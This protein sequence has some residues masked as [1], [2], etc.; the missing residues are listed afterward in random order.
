VSK[1]TREQKLELITLLEEKKKRD[2]TRKPAYIPTPS[3]KG[4]IESKALERYLF[5]GN[6]WGKS[7]L[8]VNEM[9]WAAVGYNPFTKFREPGPSKI[10]LVIDNPRKIND[11]LAEYQKWHEVKPEQLHKKGKPEISM[12]SYENGSTITVLTHDVNPLTLEGSQW[13][14]IFMDEPPPK[15]VYT[16]V[17]RGG[18]IKGRPLRLLLAGTPISAAWLRIDIWEPYTKGELNNVECFRGSTL[19]NA[20]NIEMDRVQ[21]YWQKLSPDELKIRRDGSFYDLD[22]LALAHLFR[23]ETHTVDINSLSW[24]RNNPCVLVIDPHPSKPHHAVI[25][26]VDED[27]YLYVLDEYQEKAVARKFISSLIDRGWFERYRIVDFVYDSLGNSEMTSGEGF[28]PFGNVINEVLAQNKLGRAR[29]TTYDDKNDEQFI[30]RIQDALVVPE[31][32]NNFGQRIPKLR[33]ASHC[34]GTISDIEN[35]SWAQNKRDKINKPSLDI[36]H[37]D[38]L[39]CVKYALACNLYHK[40]TKDRIYV[41]NTKAYGIDIAKRAQAKTLKLRR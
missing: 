37:K 22:G 21:D 14:H 35:V 41:P 20:I 32:P 3:Q 9:H 10:C 34:R 40:K 11:I 15:P 7:T 17:V 31:K 25:M 28:K 1:L 8:L 30:D 2:L 36:S 5:C 24:S 18:R 23:R 16:G 13:T 33:V 39:S 19:D 6:A 29:A 4:V 38:F 27:N 12:I 26:G